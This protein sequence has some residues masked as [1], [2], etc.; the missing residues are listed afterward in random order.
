MQKNSKGYIYYVFALVIDMIVYY[1]GFY[2]L[3]FTEKHKTAYIVQIILFGLLSCFITHFLSINSSS[4]ALKGFSVLHYSKTL[5][6][7]GLMLSIIFEFAFNVRLSVVLVALLNIFRWITECVLSSEFRQD[8]QS[9]LY[10]DVIGFEYYMLRILKSPFSRTYDINKIQSYIINN[11]RKYDPSV[12]FG[13]L[14]NSQKENAIAEQCCS[15]QGLFEVETA[16]YMTF[17]NSNSIEHQAIA[18]GGDFVLNMELGD[19]KNAEAKE[20][21]FPVVE[22]TEE[23]LCRIFN[24]RDAG[25]LLHLLTKGFDKSLNFDEFYQNMRQINIERRSLANFLVG[26]EYILEII[27]ISVWTFFFFL[28][29][30]VVNHIMDPAEFIKF[31][32]YPCVVFMFPW[33]LNLL[34]NFIFII[35]LH[36]FDIGDR[37][38]IE[39]DNL[40]V[41]SIG[42]T[43]TIFER[44]NNEIVVYPNKIL[45]GK[46]VKNI[47]RSK[48][49]HWIIPVTIRRKEEVKIEVIKQEMMKFAKESAEF[50]SFDVNIDE[51]ADCK[52]LRL[53][54]RIVH[55]INHQNG[56]FMWAVQNRFMKRLVLLFNELK[57]KYSPIELPIEIQKICV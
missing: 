12:I 53:N 46:V 40:I 11:N 2:F 19:D 42:L 15:F 16:E 33:I 47:R 17:S 49:Q 34:D 57:V 23:S 1:C 3:I 51:M 30:I 41:K 32:I 18:F 56:Y 27:S 28:S 7:I 44:W 37:I 20:P 22:I 4:L 45:R 24:K 29:F 39:N 48:N 35:Y 9:I 55:S 25:K 5:C 13:I 43:S 10:E 31:F 54:F 21:K 14:C 38:H 36:P 50:C 6:E 26:N 8:R 52:F